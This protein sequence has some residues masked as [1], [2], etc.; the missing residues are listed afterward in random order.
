MATLWDLIAMD[1]PEE[2]E[3]QLEALRSFMP[4]GW[5]PSRSIEGIEPIEE[6]AELLQEKPK[7][8]QAILSGGARGK[9]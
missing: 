2:R 6:I 8:K 9:A 1:T 7:G 3:R 4:K 5:E